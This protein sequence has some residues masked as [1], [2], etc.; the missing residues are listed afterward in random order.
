MYMASF[1]S[2]WKLVW[3]VSKTVK[4]F[5]LEKF[6]QELEEMRYL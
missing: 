6:L 5:L 2:C 1:N 4:Q 3:E